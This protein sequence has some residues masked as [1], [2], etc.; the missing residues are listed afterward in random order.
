MGM[1]KIKKGDTVL[2]LTGKSK[3]QTGVVQAVLPEAGK[4]VVSGVNTAIMHIK[5]DR[6]NNK[7]GEK[8][9]VE[10]PISLSNLVLVD[11]D[12]QRVK[13]GI[14]EVDGKRQRFNKKT[15]DIIDGSK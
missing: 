1:A 5:P 8:K 2:V 11:K 7:P 4:A 13:V 15:G 6:Q 12:G 9:V 14:K 10:K 3:G